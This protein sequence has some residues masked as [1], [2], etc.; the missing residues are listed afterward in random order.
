LQKNFLSI[1]DL[2]RD[3]IFEIFDLARDLK[4]KQKAGT[5][6]RYLEGKTLA[7][8]FQKPS[9]R[10]R[11]SFEV[12]MFQ[13]GGHALY[14]GPNDI[15][16][17]KRESIGDVAQTLS[18]YVDLIMARLFGH[19]DILELAK[20][21]SVPVINGLTDLLHPCQIMADLFTVFEKRDPKSKLKIVYIGD[22]NNVAN[23]WLN[24]ASKIPMTL[25]LAVPLGYEPN[26]EILT[27]AQ[28]SGVSEIQVLRDP[29]QAAK[30]ADVLYT[31]VWASMG[32]EHEAE[33]RK[34][35]FK[36]Y[37]IDGELMKAAKPDCLVMHCLPAHRGDEITDEVIDG[38]NSIVFDEA[39]NR[40]H[41]QKAILVKLGSS[42]AMP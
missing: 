13:L 4:A 19:E 5:P 39:E 29:K 6:H 23:S 22:G 34:I 15:Q 26:A 24:I 12:G 9:A 28:K 31:D 21:A 14:L 27:R 11:V 3:E 36:G 32:Q 41:V 33:K 42:S 16:I 37:R 38:P 25:H 40:L 2:T 7:M 18:R 30:D 17:G 10:T 20:F 35:A 8:I 1:A